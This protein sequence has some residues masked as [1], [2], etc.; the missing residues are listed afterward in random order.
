MP[1]FAEGLF[2]LRA[3]TSTALDALVAEIG[4]WA[5]GV[6]AATGT[7]VEVTRLRPASDFRVAALSAVPGCPYGGGGRGAAGETD[8]AP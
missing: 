1:A 2:G 4:S 8:G 6:A 7:T 3:A 5:E